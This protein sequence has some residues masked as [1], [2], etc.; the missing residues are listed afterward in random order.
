MTG[1]TTTQII[2]SALEGTDIFSSSRPFSAGEY[3]LGVLPLGNQGDATYQ[4]DLIVD[5]VVADPVPL[6]GA[7][8]FFLSGLG[9]AI[10]FRRR[11]SIAQLSRG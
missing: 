6:P 2:G 3:I 1:P 8:A 4:V 10:A 11:S 7:A 9:V 5:G